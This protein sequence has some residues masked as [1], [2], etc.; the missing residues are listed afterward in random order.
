MILSNLQETFIRNTHVNFGGCLANPVPGY[1][2][3]SEK[4]LKMF[5]II[6]AMFHPKLSSDEVFVLTDE[7]SCSY[8]SDND[9]ILNVILKIMNVIMKF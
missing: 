5:E 2:S 4:R 6:M 7:K 1:W 3:N 9:I 8:L